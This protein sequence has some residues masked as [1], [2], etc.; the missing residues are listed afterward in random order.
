MGAERLL[1]QLGVPN[2]DR[3]GGH[4]LLRTGNEAYLPLF[5]RELRHWFDHDVHHP[6]GDAPQMLHGFIN[7]ILIPWDLVRDHPSFSAA[8]VRQIDADF[9][10]TLSSKEGPERLA[11]QLWMRQIRNN[12]G[13][14]TGLDAFF[15]GR[16]FARRY[17]VPQAQR[18]LEIAD[19]YFAVQMDCGKPNEDS[20][21]HQWAASMYNTLV[22]FLAAGKVEYFQSPGFKRAADRALIAHPAGST[23][24]G[25]M[26]A[27]AAASG[28][29]GYLSGCADAYRLRAAAEMAG[30]GDEYLRSFYTARPVV[31]RADL[32]GVAEAPLDRLWYETVDGGPKPGSLFV[33]SIP[34]TAGFDKIAIREGWGPNDYYLLLDGI[35][36]GGH[37][38]QDANCIVRYAD[39]GILWCADTYKANQSATVRAQNGVFLAI[40]AAG[41]GHLH[42]A[43]QTL[44]RQLRRHHG[45]RRGPGRRGRPRLAAAYRPPPWPVDVGHRPC[46]GPSARRSAGRT[47]LAR[48]R[49]AQRRP[50]RPDKPGQRADV[51]FADHW[52]R[53][54]GNA[55]RSR[56]R[57]DG[58]RHGHDGA[59]AGNRQLLYVDGPTKKREVRLKQTALGWRVESAAAHSVAAN[60]TGDGVTIVAKQ[61]AVVIGRAAGG[62]AP[63]YEQALAAGLTPHEATLP[64]VPK[65]P[66]LA[67]PWR[68]FHV[69][70]RQSRPSPGASG[71]LGGRRCGG[72]RGRV[73]RRRKRRRAAVQLPSSI[74]ALHFWATTCWWAKTAVRSPV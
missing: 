52:R 67:I 72:Q 64:V 29:S 17:G 22:Y 21:G 55:G 19:R 44:R 48:R 33:N 60:A 66:R 47:T 16:D 39:H 70:R 26:S 59:T 11:G 50:R 43:A 61:G 23:P 74:L 18:W 30:G 68:E 32:L 73:Y 24:L 7:T 69:E 63:S 51:S 34:A 12:H 28:D 31:P 6:K 15:G 38:Y 45:N 53:G 46:R 25:Y 10:W 58:P 3:Q 40:D 65:C 8:E 1:R 57:R 5:R 20:W 41:P 37:S 54:C 9:L 35:S 4:R 36:G 42:R 62:P 13:T 56:P 49:P 71:R 27:C 2:P 14:R